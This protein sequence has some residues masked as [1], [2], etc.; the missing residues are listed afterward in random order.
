MTGNKELQ[1]PDDDDRVRRG[2]YGEPGLPNRR[3]VCGGG[4]GHSSL[5]LPFAI[6]LCVAPSAA[7]QNVTTS[8][9]PSTLDGI[10]AATHL[11]QPPTSN[12][13]PIVCRHLRGK[14]NSRRDPTTDQ[15]Y[16]KCWKR[17]P[18]IS[19]AVSPR[20]EGA[21]RVFAMIAVRRR[22]AHAVPRAASRAGRPHRSH[23]AAPKRRSHNLSSSRDQRL[24]CGRVGCRGRRARAPSPYDRRSPIADRVSVPP[25]HPLRAPTAGRCINCVDKPKFGGQ[26]MCHKMSRA[27]RAARDDARSW[28]RIRASAR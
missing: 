16:P 26:G 3:C 19:G 22:A 7:T 25:R 11:P 4:G 17:R 23:P 5:S 8:L 15:V 28:P 18:P 14:I 10:S 6:N 21:T 2:A 20:A 24:I 13:S 27:A 1:R 12:S 9:L